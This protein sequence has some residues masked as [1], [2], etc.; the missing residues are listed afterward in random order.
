[1]QSPERCDARLRRT[2]NWKRT[3]RQELQSRSDCSAWLQRRRY[4]RSSMRLQNTL[5]QTRSID[6]SP[7]RGDQ[8]N[9]RPIADVCDVRF[10]PAAARGALEKRTFVNFAVRTPG[11]WVAI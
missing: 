1:M 11:I 2:P 9:P 4:C 3:A 8:L 10:R 6:R 5:D 7:L